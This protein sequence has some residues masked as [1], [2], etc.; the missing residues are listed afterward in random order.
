MPE[1][2]R[3]EDGCIAQLIATN[4]NARGQYT[5]DGESLLCQRGEHSASSPTTGDL[6]RVF[7]EMSLAVEQ[8]RPARRFPARHLKL[9]KRNRRRVRVLG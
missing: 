4:L 2:I 9:D 3:L 6:A 8:V 5:F 1:D 7:V